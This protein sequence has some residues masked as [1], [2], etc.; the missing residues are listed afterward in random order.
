MEGLSSYRRFLPC[1]VQ[2]AV[3]KANAQLEESERKQKEV[4]TK[5]REAVSKMETLEEALVRI[6]AP[7]PHRLC[8]TRC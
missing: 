4:E 7:A 2:G 5:A 6:P 1:G 3:I 8:A